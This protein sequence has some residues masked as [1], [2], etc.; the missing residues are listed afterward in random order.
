MQLDWNELQVLH[1]ILEN[2]IEE[3]EDT[4]DA[5]IEDPVTFTNIESFTET[6]AEHSDREVT[7]R[8]ILEK[9]RNDLNTQQAG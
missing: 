6:M 8:E 9:V 2:H 7:L 1:D 5:M 3:M 4:K